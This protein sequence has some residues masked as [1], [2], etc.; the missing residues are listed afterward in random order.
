MTFDR[1]RGELGSSLSAPPTFTQL[2][3]MKT[4]LLNLTHTTWKRVRWPEIKKKRS[5][6]AEP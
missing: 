2:S 6:N 5:S 1:R 3:T 4:N